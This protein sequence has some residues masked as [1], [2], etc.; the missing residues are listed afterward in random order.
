MGEKGF[1]ALQQ[2]WFRRLTTCSAIT[3]AGFT[4]LLAGLGVCLHLRALL[5]GA[6]VVA[7][8][9]V[10]ALLALALAARGWVLLGAQVLAGT[11]VAHAVAQSYLFPFAAPA[12]A[13]SALL[14]VASVLPY[15]HGRPL[16][17]L[18]VGSVLASLAIALLPSMSALHDALP[19]SAQR[20]IALAALTAATIL[21]AL[22]LLQF[23]ERIRRAHQAEAAARFDAE[24]TR[25]ALEGAGQRLGVALSA[26]GI[27]IWDI[28]LTSQALALDDRCHAVLGI[29]PGADLDY[30]GFLRLVHDD[31]RQR[32]HDA[33]NHVVSGEGGGRCV[34][35]YRV[36]G[37][38]AGPRWIRSTGQRLSDGGHSVRL[39]GTARDVTA[40]KAKELELRA[41]KEKAEE[42][43]RAKDEFLAM[44]GHELRNP[45]APM[46]TALELLRMRLGEAGARERDVIHRQVRNLAQL[47]D[48]MLDVAQIRKGRM[49]I[50]K[51]SIYARQ[52]VAQALDLVAPLLEE[53]RHRLEVDIQPPALMLVGDERRLI[54]A[55]TNLLTNAVKY[56]DPGGA[57]RVAVSGE[58]GQIAF[59]VRDTGRGIPADFLPRVFDLFVQGERTPD[60]TEG[61]LGLGLPIVRSIVER[62]GGTVS[63]ASAGVGSGSEFVIRLPAAD[64]DTPLPAVRAATAAYVPSQ[65]KVLIID[66]NT[67]AADTLCALLRDCGFTC[68]SALDGPSGLS[69]V[70]S[71]APEVILLDLGLPGLDGYEVTR[72]IRALP[73]GD[74]YLTIAVT[75]YGQERDRER[76]AQAGF[77][78]HL[79]KPVDI[80]QLLAILR[81]TEHDA[82]PRIMEAGATNAQSQL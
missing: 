52:I 21:T 57:I 34:I 28:D 26:A 64:A 36:G 25:H 59:A 9:F 73:G 77:D 23:S 14:S 54:Q 33:V 2:V 12:L 46:L 72:R 24:E 82:A 62:H 41:A 18:V 31:D 3:T 17:W 61:G 67:D 1:V 45:L 76:A 37:R 38:D 53:R 5:L 30:G 32:V 42:A 55:L 63:A 79:V 44:L 6:A 81:T 65:R 66:D 13:V 74:R 56:T 35:E 15:V 68:A 8:A 58:G 7:V 70:A 71:F 47:V 29:P 60:R 4:A 43:N 40:D 20:L 49:T 78:A 27:G 69:T 22:L 75:G 50:E 48:D 19:V 11:G 16:R 10:F 51:Q 39:I 80:E